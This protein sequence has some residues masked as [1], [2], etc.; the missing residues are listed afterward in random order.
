MT[1]SRDASSIPPIEAILKIKTG[2]YSLD[3]IRY[4]SID[5]YYAK[6]NNGNGGK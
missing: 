1:V 5:I 6:P 3:E 4:K 2:P